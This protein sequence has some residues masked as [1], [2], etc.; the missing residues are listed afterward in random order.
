[1]SSSPNPER[2]SV[3]KLRPLSVEEAYRQTW[4]E[5]TNGN[6]IVHIPEESE[7]V[8]SV[9][10]E[11]AI[12][13]ELEDETINTVT[14]ELNDAKFLDSSTLGVF[15]RAVKRARKKE[16]KEFILTRPTDRNISNVFEVT[17]L[18]NFFWP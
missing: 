2:L 14:V 4:V 3:Q 15:I 18:I 12:T 10:I 17:G 16:G 6:S 13:D 1:M 8:A 5:I 11:S 9:A 7:F